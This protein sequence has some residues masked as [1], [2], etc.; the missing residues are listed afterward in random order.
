[1]PKTKNYAFQI[2]TTLKSI[3]KLPIVIRLKLMISLNP[4]LG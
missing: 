4:I 3:I 1:M 2:N